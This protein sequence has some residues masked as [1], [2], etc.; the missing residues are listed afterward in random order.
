MTPTVANGRIDA[1]IGP[2]PSEFTPASMAFVFQVILLPLLIHGFPVRLIFMHMLSR[3]T[4]F[5]DRPDNKT[6]PEKYRPPH[7]TAFGLISQIVRAACPSGSQ[8][9]L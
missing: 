3:I 4:A 2:L 7:N 9:I 1:L 5:A 6:R 8:S